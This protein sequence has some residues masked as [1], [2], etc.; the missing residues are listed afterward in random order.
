MVEIDSLLH[1]GYHHPAQ[2]PWQ[3]ERTL[4]KS[5]LMYPIFVTHEQDSLTPI[6]SMPNQCRVGVNRLEEVV[7]PLVAKGLQSVMLF[8]V[9]DD[10][11]KDA[12]GTAA[13]DP[14]GPVIQATRLLKSKFPGLLVACDVCLCEY[15]SHGHCGHLYPDN[16]IDNEASVRRLAEVAVNYAKAG[17]D[18]VAPSDMMD[19]RM[20]AIKQGLIDA[21]V[22][23]RVSLMAYSAKFASA[24]YGPFRDAA[25]SGAQFGDRSAYQLPPPS[26]G[27]ARRA[28][29]RDVREGADMIMVKPAGFYMDIIRDAKELAPNHPIAAYQV[30]GE[31]ATI[32]HAAAAG[33]YELKPAV[34]ESM[35]GLLRAGCNIVITY[36]TPELL[37]WLS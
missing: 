14:N 29:E 24:L 19:G 13:D 25:C 9:P 35:T 1:S 21:G 7:G 15:T 5:A 37:V 22:S 10:F 12:F 36:F 4:T 32:H 34:L 8:G 33:V 28:I 26:R 23:H 3:A 6:P 16:T 20:R 11:V 2:R 31:Y 27:L 30:S 18:C 17:A